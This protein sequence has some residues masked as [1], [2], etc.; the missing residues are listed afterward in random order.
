M[1]KMAIRWGYIDR[2][3]A[4]NVERMKVPRNPAR[5]LNQGEIRRLI[6]A[7]KDSYIH[8]FIVTAIHTGMRK[9]EVRRVSGK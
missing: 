5:F 3:A 6:E 2:N 9:S 1:L 8:P 4:S 7:S